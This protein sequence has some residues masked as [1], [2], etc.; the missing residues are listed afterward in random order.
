MSRA[1]AGQESQSQPQGARRAVERGRGGRSQP[2]PLPSADRSGRA[3]LRT[4]AELAGVHVSTVSRVLGHPEGAR[5]VASVQTAERIRALALE[6]GYVPNP[7]AIGLRTQRSNVVG[8]LT[9]RL[10]DVVMA[11]IYEG[12]EEAAGER[13]LHTFVANS[14]DDPE[15]RRIKVQVLL[16]RR[17]D[18]LVLGDAPIDAQFCDE[19]ARR[20]VPFVLVNRRA[21]H[22][23]S[24][25]CDDYRGGR[26]V[27]EHLLTLGH[28]HPAV[29]AG[30]PY[31]STG[32][33]RT[34]G[35][36]DCYAEAGLA[37]PADRVVPSH[38]DVVG[39]WAAATTLLAR[40]PR[41]TALFAVNDFAAIGAVG[42]MR[43]V[44]VLPGRDIALV[45]YNDIA[46]AAALWVPLTTVSS[47]MHEMGR[48]AVD[49]LIDRLAGRPTPSQRLE[50]R[51]IVRASCCAP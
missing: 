45:G 37:I 26:L 31:A 29:I 38:F 18:G 16:D 7:H 5:G 40:T 1:E 17:V 6:T 8:V 13:G 48:R 49:L 15:Q 25:T 4:V 19:L 34:A 39:G 35:F 3:T 41:P 14:R 24:V 30:E 9:P 47:P 27:A 42:A 23:P 36:V 44:G 51:L 28:E 2:S 22:H 33:D 46:V 12:I 10:S 21:G 43:D 32:V 50:P 20:D 11:T